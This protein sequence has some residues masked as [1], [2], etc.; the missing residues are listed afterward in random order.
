MS[1][2]NSMDLGHGKLFQNKH[3]WDIQSLNILFKYLLHNIVILWSGDNTVTDVQTNMKVGIY[4]GYLNSFG[5]T[6]IS[7]SHCPSVAC[8]AFIQKIKEFYTNLCWV[9]FR[10]VRKAEEPVLAVQS[11]G[12]QGEPHH[13]FLSNC[14]S[15]LLY[16]AD[17]KDGCHG[18]L[19]SIRFTS[20]HWRYPYRRDPQFA[21]RAIHTLFSRLVTEMD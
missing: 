15:Q 5:I 9:A 6:K 8:W 1:P 13:A 16:L 4:C 19:K 11:Q 18:M 12:F 3:A 10:I 7:Q 2:A 21:L 20:M 14:R 17:C